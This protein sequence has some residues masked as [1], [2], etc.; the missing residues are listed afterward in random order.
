MV[1]RPD[2]RLDVSANNYSSD[3]PHTYH[4][5]AHGSTTHSVDPLQHGPGWYDLSVGLAGDASWS[6]RYVGHLENGEHSITG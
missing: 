3:R 6:R 5:P 4:V 1:R 2:E